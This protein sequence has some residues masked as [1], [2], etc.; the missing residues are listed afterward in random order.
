MPAWSRSRYGSFIALCLLIFV[1]WGTF[2]YGQDAQPRADADQQPSQAAPT[3]EGRVEILPGITGG[4]L[5]EL[6]TLGDQDPAEGNV[7]DLGEPEKQAATF[8]VG[9]IPRGD[10]AK[11]LKRLQAM[12]TGLGDLLGRP[13]EILPMNTFS[14]MIDAHTL[15]RIDLA[16]YSASAFAMADRLCRCVEPLIVP[17]A[18]DGTE[19]YRAIIVTRN[20]GGIRDIAGLRNKRIAA[21]SADSIG[22]YRMQMAALLHDGIDVH[23]HFGEVT[24]TGSGMEALRLVRDGRADAAFVW[25]SMA[26]NQS[27]GYSRGPLALLVRQ[28][29]ATM[30]QFTVI[31]QSKPIAHAP[32]AVL[33]S[34]SAAERNA[35]RTYFMALPESDAETYDLL[36]TYYGGGYTE[37]EI[38]DFR[39]VSVLADVD[40]S[41]PRM[42]TSGTAPAVLPEK[43]PVVETQVPAPV[44]RKRPEPPAL[45]L[46]Q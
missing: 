9:L 1:G 33:K 18:A 22:G 36:D 10:T 23:S 25:S 21:S 16:F 31:W 15:R 34:V 38:A 30:G 11:F 39:A 4:E 3:T 14:A 24:F 46:P 37:V 42:V 43:E 41:P 40:V 29:E 6:R 17:L 28:G 19:S 27:S 32:V 35:V 5:D 44:P 20:G 26:G 8:R 45:V 13:V 2:G 7:L 12:R